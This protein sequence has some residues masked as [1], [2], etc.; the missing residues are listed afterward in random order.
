MISVDTKIAHV[1]N[2]SQRYGSCIANMSS[3]P[4]QQTNQLETNQK[5]N[6]QIHKQS[7]KP[8]RHHTVGFPAHSRQAATF[9]VS[10]GSF[11]SCQSYA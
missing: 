7:P 9:F 3:T 10:I 11:L 5:H 8:P 4:E 6:H 1:P 2:A